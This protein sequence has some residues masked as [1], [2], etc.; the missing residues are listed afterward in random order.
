MVEVC[1][2]QSTQFNSQRVRQREKKD[3]RFYGL[4]YHRVPTLLKGLEAEE[5]LSI[6]NN[7]SYSLEEAVDFNEFYKKHQPTEEN[8]KHIIQLIILFLEDYKLVRRAHSYFDNNT[9]YL[10]AVGFLAGGNNIQILHRD[11]SALDLSM[12]GP[13]T[14]CSLVVPIAQAGR[15]LYIGGDAQDNKLFIECGQAICFDGNVLHAGAVSEGNPLS[16]LALHIHIDNIKHLRPPNRLDI[17]IE[18]EDNS[19]PS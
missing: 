11:V 5:I 15:D 4:F 16:H 14:P 19:I 7:D 18:E 1:K 2:S 12:R 17:E 3:L 13:C 9:I 6:S 8:K 10:S